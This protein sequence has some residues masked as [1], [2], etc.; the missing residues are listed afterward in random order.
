LSIVDG[1]PDVDDRSSDADAGIDQLD[2]GNGFGTGHFGSSARTQAGCVEQVWARI[3]EE[4]VL[5]MQACEPLYEEER[6]R[7]RRAETCCRTG[8]CYISKR[9]VVQ[10]KVQ[11]SQVAASGCRSGAGDVASNP[12]LRIQLGT[13]ELLV[14]TRQ[15]F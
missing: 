11:E 2:G 8:M 12:G 1:T 15:E 4:G 13:P 14:R 7:T 3:P 10:L 6:R 5:A 9:E